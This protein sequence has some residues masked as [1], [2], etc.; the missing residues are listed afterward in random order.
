MGL[1][2]INT[3]NNLI[4]LIVSSLLGFMAV[5]GCL[6]WLNLRNLDVTIHLPDEVYDGIASPV[7]VRLANR[8]RVLSSFLLRLDVAGKSATFPLVDKSS[9]ETDVLTIC[10]QGRG[11]KTMEKAVISSPFPINFFVRRNTFPLSASLIVFPAPR[12]CVIQG[13]AGRKESRGENFSSRKGFGG[14]LTS[15]RDYTE[16][17]PI[18]N[19]HWRL[20]AR[21][22]ELK[23][24]EM[25]TPTEDPLIIDLLSL[26]EGGLEENLSCAAFLVN[27]AL[28][29]N[30]PVGMKLGA[31]VIRPDISRPHR[32]RLLTELALYG[33]R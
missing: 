33:T 32:L 4:F 10:F 17:D 31:R 23:V 24:K 22:G 13:G 18:K 19:I 12:E 14:D 16:S 30:R 26:T 15:I 27:K 6:G 3:G 1:A 9:V 29:A 5:S 8:K 20:S 7:T 2:A 21:Q 11:K 25:A 28:R